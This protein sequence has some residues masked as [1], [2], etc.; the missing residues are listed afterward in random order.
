MRADRFRAGAALFLAGRLA[1]AQPAT[2]PVDEPPP[3]P[4]PLAWSPVGDGIATSA[5]A[6]EWLL[7]ETAL[8]PLAPAECRWCTASGLD[9]AFRR[10]FV[11]NPLGDGRG[12][13]P[14]DTASNVTWALMPV[15]TIG[16]STLLSWRETPDGPWLSRS[17]VDALVVL[18]AAF[19][20]VAVNQL[21]K[22]T[23]GRARPFVSD[24]TPAQQVLTKDPR[25]NNLSF[26]SGHATWAF[27]FATAAGTVASM[28]GSRFA[29]L[30]W[31]IGLP[32]A[33]TTAVLRMAAD[34]HW[35]SDV[36]VGSLSG[37]AFG[38]G[39]PLLLHRDG[40]PALTV[41]PSGSGVTVAV[42]W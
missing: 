12:I 11:P 24:L 21:V 28:R 26:Y 1:V 5:L 7:F 25:D 4:R 27:A 34:K 20:A 33:A 32:L 41:L 36:L 10:L 18:D 17:A 2:A 40:A 35:F 13:G 37:A 22:F 39:L 16:L 15:A 29:W 14:A 6:L 9:L 8:K 42:W 31:A 19:A 23:A 30:V 3:P 38:V